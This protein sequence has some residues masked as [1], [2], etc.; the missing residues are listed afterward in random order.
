M[1]RN[2][3]LANSIFEGF[4]D[5][6]GLMICGYEWG[7]SKED[8]KLDESDSRPTVDMSIECTFSNKS[9][10]YGPSSNTWP[11][12]KNIKKWFK[13]WG[14]PLNDENL[15]SDFDK[16]IIQTNWAYTSNAD[17]ES[18]NRFLEK[19]AVDNFIHHIEVLRPKVILFMGSKLINF[20]RNIDVWD[21][22]TTIVGPEIEPL[23]MVQKTDFD[24]TRFK[25][26]F[27]NFEQCQ[28]VCLPHPSS[29]RGLSDEYIKLFEPE[30]GTIITEYKKQKGIL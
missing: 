26:Y 9:L 12:D 13:F 21:R 7:W 4:N 27:D 6:N 25:V 8:Q 10:R 23:K 5:K 14:H 20:L 19:E 1:E 28:V 18:Y 16:C 3:N 15:G 29:S 11:Y 17:I 30:L 24:G 2:L 22:F